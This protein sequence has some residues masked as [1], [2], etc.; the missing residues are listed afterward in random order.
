MH[1]T[2][3][4]RN[5]LCFSYRALR[6]CMNSAPSSPRRRGPSDSP[7]TTLGPRLRG[8]DGSLAD[9][10]TH[11]RKDQQLR[12]SA[13][14][15]DPMLGATGRPGSTASACDGGSK[16]RPVIRRPRSGCR[17]SLRPQGSP[18]RNPRAPAAHGSTH[19]EARHGCGPTTASPPASRGWIICGCHVT[20]LCSPI[21]VIRRRIV[22]S[23]VPPAN[24]TSK[25]SISGCCRTRPST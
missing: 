2:P 24:G 4:S 15:Y 12:H 21:R 6:K 23:F 1:G 17:A 9:A 20:V 5:L 8:D 7:R 22:R 3:A 13:R 14:T 25:R 10:V 11:S 18:D 16:C 19:P